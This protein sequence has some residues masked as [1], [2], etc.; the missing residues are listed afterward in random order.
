[1]CGLLPWTVE[2]LPG[3]TWE[4]LLKEALLGQGALEALAVKALSSND[5]LLLRF[6]VLQGWG[7]TLEAP[8]PLGPMQ[9]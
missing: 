5:S 1:M 3:W 7:S 8:F 9:I 4:T 6:R 2:H